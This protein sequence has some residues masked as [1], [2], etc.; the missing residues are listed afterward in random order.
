MLYALSF[1]VAY[2]ASV[3]F[4]VMAVLSWLHWKERRAMLDA[5]LP[6]ANHV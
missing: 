5:W 4:T 6:K 3:P 2:I 1:L